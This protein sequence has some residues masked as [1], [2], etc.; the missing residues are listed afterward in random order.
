MDLVQHAKM[1]DVQGMLDIGVLLSDIPK[2]QKALSQAKNVWHTAGIHPCHV[3]EEGETEETLIKTLKS[4][5][6]QQKTVGIGES[7]LDKHYPNNPPLAA[8]EASFRTHIAFCQEH[9][10]P[11]VI[12]SR[13]AEAETMNILAESLK[14]A[15]LS[16]VIHCFTA[17]TYM[18]D[19]AIERGF[20]LG[21]TGVI[22]YKKSQDSRDIFQKTPLDKI[23]IETDSPYL[24]PVPHRGK[25]NQ[26]AN[27][28]FI[29][30]QI[31]DLKGISREE[32]A[33][34]TTQNFFKLF[35]KASLE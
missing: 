9:N 24:T 32:V 10:L 33:S 19:W 1:A 34:I 16:A 13:D 21:A 6:E 7:G 29:A 26:P 12:H 28:P 27:I 15:P 3:G 35:P 17:S 14:K 2:R 8:Q 31:A 5:C 11:L 30:Q 20:Y 25:P 22:T 4:A 23:L 18:A